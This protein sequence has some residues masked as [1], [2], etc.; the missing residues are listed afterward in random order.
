MYCELC[1]KNNA[2]H[3]MSMILKDVNGNMTANLCQSYLKKLKNAVKSPKPMV[4]D[5]Y[6]DDSKK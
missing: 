1:K 4:V 6:P 2:T 5:I 3:G